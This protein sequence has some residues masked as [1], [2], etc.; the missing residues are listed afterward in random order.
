MP[1]NGAFRAWTDRRNPNQCRVQQTGEMWDGWSSGCVWLVCQAVLE[2]HII[3]WL[4][5]TRH[6][7]TDRTAGTQLQKRN[8]MVSLFGNGSS[9]VAQE[10]QTKCK[11][12]NRSR[13]VTTR[14]PKNH[15]QKKSQHKC[16]K[17]TTYEKVMTRKQKLTTQI[18]KSHDMEKKSHNTE[19]KKSTIPKNH[20]KSW[21][22]HKKS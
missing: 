7:V 10:G 6:E 1:E 20:A 12:H 2:L 21:N 22:G 13:Q 4:V 5:E 16:E 14:R 8:Y 15:A 19:T 3:H 17:V 9:T 11:M 18:W